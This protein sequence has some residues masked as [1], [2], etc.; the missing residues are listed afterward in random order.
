MRGELIEQFVRL[1]DEKNL[2]D[3]LIFYAMYLLLFERFKTS[4]TENLKYFLCSGFTI[5]NGEEKL[6]ETSFYRDLKNRKID[7]KK[8]LFLSS[9][10]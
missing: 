8:N 10:C 6:I 3:N 9:I 1:T 7:G 4:V 2:K 5:E